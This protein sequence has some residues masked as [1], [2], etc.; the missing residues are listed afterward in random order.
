MA[1][2]VSSWRDREIDWSKWQRL[3]MREAIIQYWPEAAGA[4]PEMSDFASAESVEAWCSAS[5]RR[6]R[7]T[8]HTIPAAPAG[9]TIADMF[10][11]VAEPHLFQPTIIYDFPVAISPLSKNKKDEPD[12]VERFEVFIG[13]HGNRA[14]PSAS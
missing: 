13:G 11:T 3:S 12:W 5:M 8:C 2:T 14:T 10:E 1:S 6:T 9:K 7:R 4:K